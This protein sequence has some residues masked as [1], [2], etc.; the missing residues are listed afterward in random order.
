[1]VLCRAMSLKELSLFLD[2]ITITPCQNRQL[3]YSSDTDCKKEICF[4]GME[5]ETFANDFNEIVAVF[6]IPDELVRP[7]W[8][9]Y[10]WSDGNTFTKDEYR[11]QSYDRDTVRLLF[12]YYSDNWVYEPE[13]DRIR[14]DVYGPYWYGISKRPDVYHI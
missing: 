11:M 6:D 14:Y 8:G 5:N 12:W 3:C 2:Y 7:G 10:K 1:M 9:V 13:A 4:F